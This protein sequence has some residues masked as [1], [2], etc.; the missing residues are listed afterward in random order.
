MKALCPVCQKDC[1]NPANL[2]VHLQAKHP[3]YL[4]TS[5]DKRRKQYESTKAASRRISAEKSHA[6]ADIAPLPEVEDPERKASCEFDLALFLKSYFPKAFNKPWGKTHIKVINKIQRAVLGGGGTF[7]YGMRRRG[8]KTQIATGAAIWALLYGHKQ[9]VVLVAANMK[10]SA[11]IMADVKQR[12]QDKFTFSILH[13][14]FPEVCYPI[15]QL[16]GAAMKAPKQHINGQR[17]EITWTQERVSLPIV[18]GSRCCRSIIHVASMESAIRGLYANA[19]DGSV[20]RPSLVLVDD[21][22]TRESAKSP[23]QNE[24]R[25]RIIQDDVRGLSGDQGLTILIPCTIMYDDDLSDQLLNP[26]R[27]PEW[28]GEK[29]K[30]VETFPKNDKLWEEYFRIKDEDYKSGG[31][32]RKA[33]EFYKSNQVTMD[34]GAVL[35]WPDNIE[36]PFHSVLEQAMHLRHYNPEGF[37]TE[38][39]NEPL[40][41]AGVD[42]GGRLEAQA[43]RERAVNLD[44]WELPPGATHVTAGVDIQHK[45]IFWGVVAWRDDFGG[46][47]IDYGVYPRQ[48]TVHFK[49]SNPTPSLE[50]AYPTLDLNSRMHAGLKWVT[51]YLF[52]QDNRPEL[53][54]VDAK[55]RTLEVDAF[56]KQSLHRTALIPIQGIAGKDVRLGSQKI[57]GQIR[58]NHWIVNPLTQG[59]RCRHLIADSNYWKSFLRN[60][61]KTAVGGQGAL[62][63]PKDCEGLIEHLT[64]EQPSIKPNEAKGFEYEQ[65]NMKP[66]RSEN[67]WWDCLYYA[68]VAASKLGLKFDAGSAAGVTV[69]PGAK[70]SLPQKRR[71]V[72]PREAQ[73]LARQQFARR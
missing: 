4:D 39:Q 66:T 19:I 63:L 6:G 47:V 16:A 3:S 61:L 43:L 28:Q 17:T 14:D 48:K 36:P 69:A 32:G 37:A 51:D 42:A 31:D 72:D 12:L 64:A 46:V 9:F 40:L 71:Y 68:C 10:L 22:S 38:W 24:N 54:C 5:T 60:R 21:P 56:C 2:G 25:L 55:D 20:I 44:P 33:T 26:N 27:L 65:W 45:C 52:G 11:L 13:A 29:A 15:S 59:R 49:A 8:G 73:R 70:P 7:A 57:Q 58:G 34:E 35:D 62:L 23:A 67:H 53:A 30:A 50:D 18:E 41:P 1:K